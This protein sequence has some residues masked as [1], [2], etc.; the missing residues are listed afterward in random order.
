MDEEGNGG[1]TR[2]TRADCVWQFLGLREH[3]RLRNLLSYHEIYRA[4]AAVASNIIRLAPCDHVLDLSKERAK[5]KSDLGD[6][7]D[8]F[9]QRHFKNEMTIMSIY[10][11]NSIND[12]RHILRLKVGW[13]VWKNGYVF[14]KPPPPYTPD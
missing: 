8:V 11:S 2:W 10:A 1:H 13:F 3:L 14:R 6:G 7:L 9:K 4:D 5:I 12:I